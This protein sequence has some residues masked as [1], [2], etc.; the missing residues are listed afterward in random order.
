MMTRKTFYKILLICFSLLL[1]ATLMFA[2]A[3]LLESKY[4]SIAS[5]GE[6][7][8]RTQYAVYAKDV[9]V[10]QV[11]M[12]NDSGDEIGFGAAWS[13]EKLD[14][15]TWMTLPFKPDTA[16]NEL[17]YLLSDGGTRTFTVHIASLDYKLTDGTY[18]IVKE[19]D[20]VPVAAEFTVGGKVLPQTLSICLQ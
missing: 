15:G 10:I 6:V 9:D 14:G 4:G 3:P 19:I 1:A 18:R 16:W 2:C 11:L 12:R 5:D 17:L 8:L 13:M 20:G 7:T